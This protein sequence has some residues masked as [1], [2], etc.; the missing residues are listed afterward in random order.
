[1]LFHSYMNRLVQK[2]LVIS[3]CILIPFI[4]QNLGI[5][6][7]FV[8]LAANPCRLPLSR[9]LSGCKI[10]HAMFFSFLS[11][12]VSAATPVVA[13]W[14]EKLLCSVSICGHAGGY[15]TI[16][17]LSLLLCSYFFQCLLSI[18]PPV[19]S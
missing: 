5:L 3:V 12:S 16:E 18:R 2:L 6:I 7:F 4:M 9:Q 17:P 15:T 8:R 13:V 19:V 1:M 10:C 11:I 14:T